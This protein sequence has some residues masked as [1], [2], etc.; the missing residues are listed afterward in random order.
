MEIKTS[1]GIA[2]GLPLSDIQENNKW[3][4]VLAVSFALFVFFLIAFVL[5]LKFSG[6][7]HNIIYELSPKSNCDS[8]DKIQIIKESCSEIDELCE[9]DFI[10]MCKLS[11][12]EIVPE[13]Q[14]EIDYLKCMADMSGDTW[15]ESECGEEISRIQEE[16]QTCKK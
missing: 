8:R 6:I 9:K 16:L 13:I 10:R 12:P 7:G 4:K 3:L 11:I 14:L 5:W 1:K 15:R 2:K